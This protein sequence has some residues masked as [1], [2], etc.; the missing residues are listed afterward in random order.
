VGQKL[1][2][3]LSDL[4]IGAGY[5]REGGNHLENFMADEDLVNFLH[6]SQHES[7][8]EQCEVELIINGDFF[9]FLQVPAVDQYNPASA[10][11]KEA[12]LDSSQKASVQRLNII[13]QGHPEIFNALSDFM[14]VECPQ[15]RIT[16]IKG[17]HDVNLFWPGVKSRL[18][19]TLG[20]SGTRASLLLFADEFVSREKIYVEHGHQRAEKINCYQDFFNPRSSDDPTRLYYPPGSHFV[21]NAFNDLKREHWFVDHIKPPTTLIWYALHWN[22]E[23]ASKTLADFIR[24]ACVSGN[25]R[26]ISDDS[27]FPTSEALLQDLENDDKRREISQ[28]YANDPAFRQQ[29]HQQIQQY[30]NVANVNSKEAVTLPLPQVSD[31]PFEMGQADQQQQQMMLHRAAEKVAKREGAKVILFGH[32]HYPIQKSLSNGSVYINTGSWV[33]DFSDALPETW[34]ALFNGAH[35]F[36]DTPTRLPYARIEYDEDNLPTA[37]LLYF[38]KEGPVTLPPA[39]LLLNK[40]GAET[41]N[42]FEKTRNWMAGNLGTGG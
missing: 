2:Y 13:A 3:I 1:K 19:E 18:S 26:S 31:D 32:T 7:K 39:N 37:K 24:Y 36:H 14:H 38:K 27:L 6:E 40:V 22:F 8:R 20:A 15:R 9:E 30:L 35:P 11:P 41:K 34:E 42:L 33:Q 23:V 16:I 4:H 12:Y 21:V 28:R 5:A 17:N 29:F 10:Y 25:N